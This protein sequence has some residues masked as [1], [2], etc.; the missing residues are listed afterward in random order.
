MQMAI[1]LEE[2]NNSYFGGFGDT[3]PQGKLSRSYA[4]AVIQFE[5]WPED[6]KKVFDYDPEGAEALLDEAGY[7]RGAD[8]IRFKTELL[9]HERK[10]LNYM[11]LVTSYWSKIGIDVVDIEMASSAAFNPR[12]V[13]KDHELIGHELAN[14]AN[15][16]DVMRS[17]STLTPS[18][19]DSNVDD[20][21]YEAMLE[22]AMAAT[23]IEEQHRLVRELNQYGIEQ[24]WMIWTPNGPQFKRD[25]TVDHRFQQ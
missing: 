1:N 11:Q 6:V 16:V 14:F 5:D 24:F 17:Y 8:G 7:P 3:T 2:F 12:R 18:G 19:A 15:P 10:D 23:T 4:G 25:P 21:D 9:Q 22:V 20:P 13:A